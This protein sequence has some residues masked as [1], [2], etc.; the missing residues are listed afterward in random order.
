MIT[1]AGLVPAWALKSYLS[2]SLSAGGKVAMGKWASQRKKG[3]QVMFGQMSPPLVTD[4][5]LGVPAAGVTV[6]TRAISVPAPATHWRARSIKVL[7][8]TIQ[9]PVAQAGSNISVPTV[10]VG[11]LYKIQAAWG[12]L[13]EQYSDWTTIGTVTGA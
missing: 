13:G 6:A 1:I 7:D 2:I 9:Q 4:V 11:A 8:G 5:T 3:S 12:T 10:T